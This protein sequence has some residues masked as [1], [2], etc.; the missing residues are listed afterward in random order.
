MPSVTNKKKG[1][2]QN[3]SYLFPRRRLDGKAT[4]DSW[5]VGLSRDKL[6]AEAERRFGLTPARHRP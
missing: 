5:W 2:G 3:L 6:D 1:K 4:R